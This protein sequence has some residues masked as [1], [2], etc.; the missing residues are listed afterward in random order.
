MSSRMHDMT[1][2]S[3]WIATTESMD[4]LYRC[5]VKAHIPQLDPIPCL[6]S[7]C[8]LYCMG[9]IY[10]GNDYL[11]SNI[12][13]A[14][15]LSSLSRVSLAYFV[16]FH[17]C[18]HLRHETQ[19]VVHVPPLQQNGT[20]ALL[21]STD[22]HQEKQERKGSRCKPAPK[23]MHAWRKKEMNESIDGS[24]TD[25]KCTHRRGWESHVTETRRI[26][27]LPRGPTHG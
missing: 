22:P 24:M 1:L 26:G 13:Y 21:N 19:E 6:H 9:Y 2:Q 12:P 25:G 8:I 20:V 14:F 17:F 18:S 5:S 16:H 4:C 3:P 23:T 11:C 10:S 27:K 15:W 7:H